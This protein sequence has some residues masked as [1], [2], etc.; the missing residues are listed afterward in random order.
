MP[1]PESGSGM[2]SRVHRGWG[3]ALA[4]FLAYS[5]T[6]G[7]SQYS[8]G[9]FVGPLESEFGWSRTEIGLSLSLVALGSFVSPFFGAMIDRHGAR[10]IMA[11]S[12]LIF[13][14]SYLARPIM[15]DIWHF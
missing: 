11:I 9:H 4:C 8:F 3:I 10:K 14:F 2:M 6:V 15:N 5:A 1:E 7:G 12:M 13:G